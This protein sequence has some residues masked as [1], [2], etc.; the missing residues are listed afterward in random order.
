M[1]ICIVGAGTYGSYIAKCITERD[2][3]VSITIIEAGDKNI[4]NE[5]QIGFFSKIFGDGYK[6]LSFGRYF[7]LGGTSS[8]WGGQILT[9]SKFDFERPNNFLR[10]IININEVYKNKI[11]S[12]FNIPVPNSEIKIQDN[13][14]IKSGIWLSIFKRN[15]FYFFKINKL[16]NIRILTNTRVLKLIK[17]V[18]Q[19]NIIEYVNNDKII[20]KQFDFIFL[21]CGAFE[22]SRILLSS[23]MIQDNEVKFSDHLSKKYCSI[24]GDTKI[25]NEDYI[26]KLNYFS[27]ITKRI[28]GEQDNIS[29]YLHPVYNHK[30][31]F[32]DKLKNIL[33]LNN[34]NF[35]NIFYLFFYFFIELPVVL[36]FIN[37]FL[38]KREI[39]VL[40]NSWDLYLDIENP[41]FYNTIK[42]SVEKDKMG[43][44]GLDIN[45][46]IGDN[47]SDLLSKIEYR[48]DNFLNDN[49]INYIKDFNNIG[50]KNLEDIYHPFCMFDFKDLNDYYFRYNSLLIVNT[51]ILPRSGG[52]NPTGALFPIIE[53]FITR[54][55][56]I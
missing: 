50:T 6:G 2:N 5:N 12:R 38:L 51:G 49:K 47:T 3:S 24:Y 48:L 45:Y 13:L 9:F 19:F 25:A 17:N 10:E 22:S 20:I 29:F 43:I 31:K 55:F 16:K 39:F 37:S 33:Y 26:F 30:F 27:L 32:F 21:A 36:Q 18:D 23:N 52:I 28:V 4:R 11:Y 56:K 54:N 44:Y 40:N 46:K 34:Y 8:K 7:G 53:D 41:N 14:L 1:N 35:K 15:L 42:L